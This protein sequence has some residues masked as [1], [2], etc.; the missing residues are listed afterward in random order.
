MPRRQY[1]DRST[2]RH[3]VTM[4]Q[5]DEAAIGLASKGGDRAL[6]SPSSRTSM[7]ITATPS[8]GATALAARRNAIVGP[9]SEPNSTAARLRLGAASL[10]NPSHL[11]PIAGS[12]DW[13]P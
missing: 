5:D 7:A 3:G 11:P 8:D 12:K 1:D 4:R 9:A 10:S 2:L 13:N 6:H